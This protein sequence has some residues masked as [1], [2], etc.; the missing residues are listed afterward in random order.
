M[1]LEQLPVDAR[2][3]VVALEVAEARQLDQVAVARVVGG[4]E[5]EVGVALLLGP[6]VV[7]D[8]DLAAEDRLHALLSSLLVQLDRARQRAVVGQRDRRHLEL[9]RA[10]GERRNA[11]G[12]VEN[13]V[14][15]VDV[16]MDEGRLGHSV[17]HPIAGP[18]PHPFAEAF[19]LEV[20]RL[21]ARGPAGPCPG[22]D[23]SHVRRGREQCHDL[24]PISPQLRVRNGRRHGEEPRG[25]AVRACR[26]RRRPCPGSDP[27]QVPLRRASKDEAGGA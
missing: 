24:A 27:R 26:R 22:S 9:G 10:R 15:G 5:R 25:R 6:T 17:E 23:P 18:G 12:S 11:A 16:E 1:A 2:L 7:R 21:V 20:T 4:E 19:A 3:V 8:V 14:L 13:R